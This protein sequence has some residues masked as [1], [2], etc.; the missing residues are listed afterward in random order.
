M[1][2]LT[3]ALIPAALFAVSFATHAETSEG[4]VLAVSAGWA[5]IMPQGTKQGVSTQVGSTG[6]YLPFTPSAGFELKD[7]DTAEFKFDYLVDDNV[8]LGLIVG[9]PPTFD[10]KGKGQLLGGAL[11]LDKFS[12]VG[13]VKV[14]SPVVTGKYT[15]GAVN[16]K[17]RPYVGAGLMY[18]HFSNFK[19]D[20][21]VVSDTASK[22]ISIRNVKIDDAVAPVA[23]IGADYNI[24]KNWFATASV[25]YVHLST[26][27]KLDVA[28]NV[29][30]ATLVTGRSKIE[31]NPIVTY[32]G[33]GYRF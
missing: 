3:K 7:S 33:V 24:T 5:H 28:N 8:S 14:Y 23:F 22:G 26:N 19:L 10:I 18:A 4:K 32:L 17:L 11:N 27:A 15:F 16:N 13:D 6:P 20:S 25:S 1:K 2:K 31:I 12:K 29:T 9:V 30:G 21:A